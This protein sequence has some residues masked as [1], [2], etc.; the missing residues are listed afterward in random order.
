MGFRRFLVR[1]VIGG[2]VVQQYADSVSQLEEFLRVPR[3]LG[4]GWSFRSVA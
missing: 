1:Y 3:A 2:D 4:V